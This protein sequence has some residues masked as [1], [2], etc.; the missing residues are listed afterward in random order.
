MGA[1]NP[2]GTYDTQ[3][4][5]RVLVRAAVEYCC[6]FPLRA[7]TRQLPNCKRVVTSNAY[8][9]LKASAAG[10]IPTNCSS[11]LGQAPQLEGNCRNFQHK[12]VQRVSIR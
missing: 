1:V 9:G 11:Q 2:G 3:P 5:P 12:L 8:R 6:V 10:P 7:Q 4:Q